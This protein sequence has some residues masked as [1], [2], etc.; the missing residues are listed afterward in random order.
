MVGVGQ[1]RRVGAAGGLQAQA[2]GDGVVEVEQGADGG[3]LFLGHG[4][5]AE[6]GGGC[7]DQGCADRLG[8]AGPC[9]ALADTGGDDEVRGVGLAQDRLHTGSS[10]RGRR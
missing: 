4:V 8:D 1:F 5:L 10:G 2:F 7:P 3:G 9:Q 6:E